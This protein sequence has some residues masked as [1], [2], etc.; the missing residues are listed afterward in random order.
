ML[1]RLYPA[2]WRERYAEE[3]IQILE[4]SPPTLLT[5]CNLFI[6]L[7]DACMH[8]NL[9]QGRKFHILQ[10][11]RSNGLVIYSATLL[12]FAAWFVVQLHVHAPDE[13][14]ILLSFLSLSPG[15]LLVN[16][17][18][19]VTGLL[20][21]TLALGGLPL[22]LAAC[23]K[24][25]QN[26]NGSALFLCLLGLVSP[27]VTLVLV[28]LIQVPLL[29][30]PFVILA[31]L[32]VDLALIFFA[33][34]HVAPSRRVTSYALHLALLIPLIMLIGLATLLPAILPSFSDPGND[35]F[36]VMREG[37]LFLIMGATFVCALVALKQGFQ[38]RQTLEFPLQQE[39]I[40]M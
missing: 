30:A 40:T 16:L 38:A 1:I 21:L 12:F 39:T 27:I 26:R 33:V 3:M 35:P 36:Y 18:R 32:L 4:D 9:V 6:S 14:R 28:I 23:W 19:F 22:L 24:A 10:K 34:Q 29:V 2:A 11:M 15:H 13:P 20:L 5:L 17:V 8:Q 25:V 31:G 37:S 7:I